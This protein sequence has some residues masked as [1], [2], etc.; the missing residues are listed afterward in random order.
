MGIKG[1]PLSFLLCFILTLFHSFLIVIHGTM[2]ISIILSIIDFDSGE[3]LDVKGQ[4]GLAIHA[5]DRVNAIVVTKYHIKWLDISDP[6]TNFY[7][8]NHMVG[9]MI[10]AT[11]QRFGDVEYYSARISMEV[12]EEVVA[13]DEVLGVIPYPVRNAYTTALPTCT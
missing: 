10:F 11:P 4:A 1:V 7:P 8:K 2:Q 6:D 5:P 13:G 3:T 12:D 9:S